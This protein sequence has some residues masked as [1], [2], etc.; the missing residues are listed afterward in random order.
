MALPAYIRDSLRFYDTRPCQ[1]GSGL[2]REELVDARG[3]S[4]GLCC[5]KCAAQKASGYR[6][7]VFAD[8][9]YEADEPIEPDPGSSTPGCNHSW[10][11][12]GTAYGGDVESYHGEG[13]MYCEFCGADGDA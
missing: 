1:C 4:C 6:R 5:E 2:M 11:C 8:G 12:T 3:I 7:E 13:R 10:V 9:N